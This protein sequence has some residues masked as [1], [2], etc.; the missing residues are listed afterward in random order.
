M[1]ES[2][3]SCAPSGTIFGNGCV[4]S[5]AP[6]ATVPVSAECATAMEIGDPPFFVGPAV[7]PRPPWAGAVA[8]EEEAHVL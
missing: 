5:A 7:A 6:V 8:E 4:C 2:W 1:K 3:G